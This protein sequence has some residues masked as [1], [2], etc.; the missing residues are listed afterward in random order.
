MRKP[1]P[2]VDL[3]AFSTNHQIVG[4]EIYVSYQVKIRNIAP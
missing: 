4:Y 2:G 3:L 1:I